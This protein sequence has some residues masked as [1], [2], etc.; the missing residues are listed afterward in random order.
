MVAETL[1]TVTSVTAG[2]TLYTGEWGRSGSSRTADAGAVLRFRFLGLL[3]V[4]NN[5]Q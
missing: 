4:E 5:L 3:R 2:A 1:R